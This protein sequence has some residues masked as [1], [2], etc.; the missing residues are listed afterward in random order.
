MRGS[1]QPAEEN[2]RFGSLADMETAATNVRFT[3]MSGHAQRPNQCLLCANN[4]PSTI[5]IAL[6]FD[7]SKWLLGGVYPPAIP[8]LARP[9]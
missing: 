3:P 4:G 7:P 8:S 1:L 2:V 9:I 6:R 5:R